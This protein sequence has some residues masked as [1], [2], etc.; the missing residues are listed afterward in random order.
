MLPNMMISSN[1]ARIDDAK[2]SSVNVV[3]KRYQAN[4]TAIILKNKNSTRQ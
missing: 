4:A 2:L 3:K 1:P